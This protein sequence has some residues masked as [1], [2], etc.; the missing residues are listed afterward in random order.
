MQ[1]ALSRGLRGTEVGLSERG[2]V[3]VR[4]DVIIS[5]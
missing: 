3:V 5:P 4:G 1:G 2:I